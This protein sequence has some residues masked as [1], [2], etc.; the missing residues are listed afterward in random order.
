MFQ[1]CTGL[2]VTLFERLVDDV[3]PRYVEAEERRLSQRQ[4][5]RAMG[6]G[7]PF[8]LT[9]RDHLLLTVIWLRLYPIREVLAYL[10]GISDSTVSRLI[11]QVL[12]ILEQSGRDGMRLPDLGKKRRR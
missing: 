4:R 2:T 3:R 5:Q 1:K 12:P 11:E 10:F 7:H 6:A 8:E 9:L